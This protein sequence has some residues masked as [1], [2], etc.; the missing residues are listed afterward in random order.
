MKYLT[1]NWCVASHLLSLAPNFNYS[2]S[3]NGCSLLSCTARSRLWEL[4][5]AYCMRCQY[6]VEKVILRSLKVFFS[7]HH[8]WAQ[9]S[10]GSNVQVPEWLYLPASGRNL[11]WCLLWTLLDFTR[12]CC[13]L[14]RPT[15]IILCMSWTC[16]QLSLCCKG[17][18]SFP[19]GFLCLPLRV[20]RKCMCLQSGGFPL[21][22]DCVLWH[23]LEFLELFTLLHSLTC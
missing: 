11:A 13:W 2:S 18:L 22:G 3:V 6:Y 23:W 10:L 12:C 14:S 17:A 8:L 4:M 15:L 19:C 20:S 9:L 1:L 21:W 7:S 5:S 16:L